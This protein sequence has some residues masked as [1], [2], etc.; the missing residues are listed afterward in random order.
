MGESRQVPFPTAQQVNLPAWSSHCPF[1]AE[2]QAG[3]LW[4]LIIKSFVWPN[5]ESNPSLQ[6]KRQTLYTTRPSELLKGLD[7]PKP[8][9]DLTLTL[10]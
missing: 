4:I 8:N 10:A 5:S 1:N 9:P 2:R 6:L 7:N 3:K